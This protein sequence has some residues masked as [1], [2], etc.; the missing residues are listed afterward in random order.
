[1]IK[2]ES[3]KAINEYGICGYTLEK[4]KLMP[5]RK[6]PGMYT[7]MLREMYFYRAGNGGMIQ[8]TVSAANTHSYRKYCKG[9]FI[10]IPEYQI[11]R[12]QMLAAGERLQRVNKELMHLRRRWEGIEV[13]EI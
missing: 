3:K 9:D 7:H 11:L 8:V 2:V 4:F 5:R 6:L 12:K 10:P 13:I 1:M